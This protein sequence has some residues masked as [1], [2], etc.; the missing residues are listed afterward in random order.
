[1]KTIILKNPY[2]DCFHDIAKVVEYD[3]QNDQNGFVCFGIHDWTENK[4]QEAFANNTGKKITYQLE[5]LGENC[6]FATAEYMHKLL[7]FDEVWEYS[8]HNFEFLQKHGIHPIYKPVLPSEALREPAVEK[9]I[10]VLHFGGLNAH[11]KEYL[12]FAIE[13]GIEI[14]D[15][16]T[17]C[18]RLVFDTEIHELLRSSKVVLGLHNFPEMPIQEA[19]RY[20][21]P[22]SNGVQILAE[23]SLSNPLGLE[24]F[25]TK[26][27]MVEK[28]Q[29]MLRNFEKKSAEE[30]VHLRVNYH[31]MDIA[32][33]HN[34]PKSE[35]TE[36]NFIFLHTAINFQLDAFNRKKTI[37]NKQ[38]KHYYSHI[39]KSDLAYL[40]N[41]KNYTKIQRFKQKLQ[42]LA[43]LRNYS[44][45]KTTIFM[46]YLSQYISKKLYEKL[47]C[48]LFPYLS[49]SAFLELDS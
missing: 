28:L 5:V 6:R 47:Y 16:R 39:E 7:Q 44:L 33:K 30:N 14:I 25:S 1:M 37:P 36:R 42:N 4:I 48:R 35:I 2:H 18:K 17:T 21:Y 49:K 38:M 19:V 13:H 26:E 11:R 23:K 32:K 12:N 24:E 43:L 29:K 34:K 22:L 31:I 10:D 3:T 15:I 27:E 8:L 9:Y 20:Q 40:L 45:F 46:V 41:G